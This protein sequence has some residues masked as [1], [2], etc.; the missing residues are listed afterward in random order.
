[1]KE[2]EPS[3]NDLTIQASEAEKNKD[4]TSA[5]KL[6][7]EIIKRDHLHI[8]SYDRLMKIYRQ[9]KNYKKE[10]SIINAAIKAYE[11][12][13]K[14]HAGKHSKKVSD[15]SEKLN[16]SFGLI[17]KKGIKLYNPEPV[18]RWLKRKEMANKKINN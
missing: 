2:N 18:G 5:I 13:Y 6:Y 4:D 9:E 15:I 16:R 17:D 11:K 1:M 3:I 7:R 8:H 14:Q 12:Y 10:I